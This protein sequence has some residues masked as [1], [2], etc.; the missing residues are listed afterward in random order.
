MYEQKFILLTW[1]MLYTHTHTHIILCSWLFHHH[2]CKFNIIKNTSATF[3]FHSTIFPSQSFSFCEQ[4]NKSETHNFFFTVTDFV[5]IL[6]LYLS[7]F[8]FL[9]HHIIIFIV[10][11]ENFFCLYLT[12]PCG[13]TRNSLWYFSSLYFR[14]LG[15][16]KG[17]RLKLF[18]GNYKL[19]EFVKLYKFF[20]IFFSM[21]GYHSMD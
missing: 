3:S 20:E 18:C 17:V 15:K 5:N 1:G 14:V 8:F 13:T 2:G 16:F 11:W 21:L 7:S 4:T 12:Y 9:P 10:M 19:F 6:C